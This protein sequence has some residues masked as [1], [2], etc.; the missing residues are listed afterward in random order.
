[1]Q[2]KRIGPPRRRTS[3]A[4]RARLI[5]R[6][7]SSGLTRVAFAR[8]HG[9][10]VSTL[11]GWLTKA[12]AAARPTPVPFREV[13]WAGVGSASA[14]RWAMEIEGAGGLTI[15]LREGLRLRDLAVLLRGPSYGRF[16]IDNNLIENDIPPTAVGRKRWLFI[17]HPQAGWRSAVIYSML[18]SCRR[19]GL[20]PQEY[21]SDIL[22]RL[23]PIKI[24]QISDL[25]PARNVA[26][27]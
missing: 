7:Q 18:I 9:V 25:L 5:A 6:F 20:N 8:R 21:L 14:I 13:S 1:M 26:L 10:G 22:A 11:G 27:P 17:G 15:R 12:R 3:S 19:R 16:E 23:P 4:Q 2:P 24:T